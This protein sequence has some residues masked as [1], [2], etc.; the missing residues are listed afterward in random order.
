[1]KRIRTA[2]VLLLGILIAGCGGDQAQDGNDPSPKPVVSVRV[3]PVRQQTVPVTVVVDGMTDVRDRE[4]VTAP[5]DGTV[6]S[7]AVEVGAPV[8]AGDT[9][10][11]LRTRDSEAAIAGARRLM[12]RAQT[13]EQRAR[14]Q[15]ALDVARESQQLVSVT[16]GRPGMVVARL[17]SPGQTV[18]ADARLLE[19]VDLS[20]L[21]FVA[22]VPLA[23]LVRIRP[24]QSARIDFPSLPDTAFAARVATVSAQSDPGSQ[25]TPV[26]LRF[27]G[28]T[29]ALDAT[30]RVSMMGTATITVSEHPGA[31]VVPT[32]ALLRDDLADTYTVYLVGPDSLA[33]QISVTIGVMTDSI[34]EV[35]SP[36][37]AAGDPVIVEGNY[38]VSDSTRVTV[39]TGETP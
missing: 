19:L 8:K 35:S 38:E 17:A 34:A 5:I 37:L 25:A 10:A 6:V 11:V 4:Q 13:P 20:T 26:R 2:A 7:L 28:R 1:M 16:A 30:L 24:G 36:S 31:L 18:T 15:S 23:E 22:S 33:H 29:A 32:P 3:A 12:E 39:L 14:A 27:D 21:D 9:I